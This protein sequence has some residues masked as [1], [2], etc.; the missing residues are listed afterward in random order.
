FYA[1]SLGGRTPNL[2]ATFTEDASSMNLYLNFVRNPASWQISLNYAK[3]MGGETPYD[4]L[5]RDRD[6]VGIAISRTL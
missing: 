6:Y 2:S 5:Y 1:R 4:Q 3:F